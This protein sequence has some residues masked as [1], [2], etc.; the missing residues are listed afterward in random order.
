MQYLIDDDVTKSR[1]VRPGTL[2]A[3]D[4]SDYGAALFTTS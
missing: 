2:Q 3:R 1:F 4:R